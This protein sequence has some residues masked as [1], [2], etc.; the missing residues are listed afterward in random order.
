MLFLYQHDIT[1][2]IAKK[3]WTKY[4]QDTIRR[5]K[6]NPYMLCEDVYGIGFVKADEIATKIG[7]PKDRL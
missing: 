1:G 5:I 2:S 3:L 7:F 6:D 4:G